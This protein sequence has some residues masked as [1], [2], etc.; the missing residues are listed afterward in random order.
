MKHVG[1]TLHRARRRAKKSAKKGVRGKS[2]NECRTSINVSFNR[3]YGLRDV[4]YRNF[5]ENPRTSERT[6][7]REFR[8]DGKGEGGKSNPAELSPQNTIFSATADKRRLINAR[9]LLRRGLRD[10]AVAR[11]LVFSRLTRVTAKLL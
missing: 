10:F 1:T 7:K 3:R 11:E 5:R 4:R 9:I 8:D 2:E 6:N